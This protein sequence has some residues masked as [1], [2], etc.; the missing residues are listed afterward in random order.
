[1]AMSEQ[2]K[3]AFSSFLDDEASELDIQRMLKELDKN[4][5][6]LEEYRAMALTRDGIHA[7]NGHHDGPVVDVSAAIR[8][9]LGNP[10]YPQM[11]TARQDDDSL[12]R[13]M[14]HGKTASVAGV[15]FA[16]AGNSRQRR[17]FQGAVAAVVAGVLIFAVQFWQKSQLNTPDVP[18][19]QAEPQDPGVETE[20][21]R[22]ATELR[23]QQYLQQHIQDA[24]YLSG[25]AAIPVDPHRLESELKQG[26]Q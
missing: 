9:Q 6:L 4:P 2:A 8:R 21:Q 18:V 20:E 19:A 22:L 11:E 26:D 3:E 24:G 16:P 14:F 15:S 7:R 13:R 12:W 23:L 1:M 25:Q 10:S 5:A 17:M